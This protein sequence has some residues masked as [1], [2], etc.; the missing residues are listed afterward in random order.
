MIK[1]V[2]NPEKSYFHI[3]GINGE[4]GIIDHGDEHYRCEYYVDPI[5]EHSVEDNEFWEANDLYH[6]GYFDTLAEALSELLEEME[7]LH[8]YISRILRN[9]KFCSAPASYDADQDY[10]DWLFDPTCCEDPE[11]DGVIQEHLKKVKDVNWAGHSKDCVAE[12]E[13]FELYEDDAHEASKR[14]ERAEY[15]D[16][17]AILSGQ[18]K[19]DSP[20]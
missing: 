6:V 2:H 14:Y 4:Y 16:F 17:L 13:Y 15:F 19:V 10:F 12:A 18:R 9:A 1:I 20:L 3:I 7:L 5:G 8:P 11:V